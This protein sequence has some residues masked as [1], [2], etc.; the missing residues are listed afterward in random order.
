VSKPPIIGPS[1]RANRPGS[2]LENYNPAHV[3]GLRQGDEKIVSVPEV[4]RWAPPKVE[5]QRERALPVL[6]KAR[7]LFKSGLSLVGALAEAGH[8]RI[9]SE[10]ARRAL[11]EV[12]GEPD[13]MRWSE[14]NKRTRHEVFRAIDRAVALCSKSQ[15]RGGWRVS[16]RVLPGGKAA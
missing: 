4:L 5:E 12:L 13:L 1:S 16:A 8:A 3:L 14:H 15:H 7:A 10:Y 2:L 9:E 6:L 11:R